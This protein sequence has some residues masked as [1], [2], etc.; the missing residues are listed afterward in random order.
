MAALFMSQKLCFAIAEKEASLRPAA[1][2]KVKACPEHA[3]L[4]NKQHFSV[5]SIALYDDFIEGE[6]D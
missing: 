3:A 1:S 4:L 5:Y 2:L 6:E